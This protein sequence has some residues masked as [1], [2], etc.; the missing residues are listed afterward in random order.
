LCSVAGRDEVTVDP[1]INLP[2]LMSFRPPKGTDDIG[3]PESNRWRDVLRHWETW[4]E[5]FGYPLVM[6]PVFESTDLFE[7]GVGEDTEVVTKQM[8]S[9]TDRGGRLLTLRPE[10]TAGVVRAFL[11]SG[12]KG[13]WKGAYSGPMFRHERPQAGRRRQ[14]WQVGVE[15]LDVEG[16]ASDAEVIELGYRFLSAVEVPGLDVL[17]NSLGD[18]VCR[19]GYVATLRSYLEEKRD[20]LC[21]DSVKLID[22]NPLRVLDCSVCAPV[23]ADAPAMKDHLC[24]PCADHYALVKKSL[25]D[26][27]IP[28]VEDARLVRGLDYYT[29]TAFEYIAT[30]L[31]AAQNA[32]GGGGRYDGLAESIGGRRAPGV[33]F[34][35][36]VDRIVLASGK[37]AGSEIDVYVVSE[38]GPDDALMAASHLRLAGLRVD[39][40]TEGRRVEAQFKTASRLEARAVIVLKA[41]G[42]EVDV[43]IDEERALMPL[44]VVPEFLGDRL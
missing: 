10:G 27:S 21:D 44:D 18:A 12:F 26:L 8:Y 38:T 29:R 17:L 23:L 1:T 4:A 19:P 33:G 20:S 28:Y 7:R 30:D 3:A 16:P 25:E 35:L 11:D 31:D 15:Y 14:F 37:A 13:A 34:A 24:E 39:F 6:T 41:E 9:F 2:A 36:G 43:R 42:E 40:D 22:V 32:V 5:L